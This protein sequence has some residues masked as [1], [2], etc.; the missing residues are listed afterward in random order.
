MN[1]IITIPVRSANRPITC[2]YIIQTYRVYWTKY[3]PH[4]L[5]RVTYKTYARIKKCDE[6]TSIRVR[7]VSKSAPGFAGFRPQP[8]AAERATGAPVPPGPVRLESDD[9]AVCSGLRRKRTSKQEPKQHDFS[10]KHF[11]W[12]MPLLESGCRKSFPPQKRLDFVH[13]TWW[14]RPPGVS[15]LERGAHHPVSF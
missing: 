3:R 6:R 8:A 5:T 11:R 7:L 10:K 14:K 13:G 12:R 4:G 1:W 9:S 2:F 15:F